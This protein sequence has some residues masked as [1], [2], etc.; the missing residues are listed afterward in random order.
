MITEERAISGIKKTSLKVLP[1]DDQRNLRSVVR[2]IKNTS[3]KF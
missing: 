2:G 1:K 3:L